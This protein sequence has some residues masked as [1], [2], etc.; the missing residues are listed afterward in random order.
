MQLRAK[1]NDPNVHSNYGAYLRDVAKDDARAEQAYLRALELDPNHSN[2][3]GNLANLLWER[4]ELDRAEEFYRHALEANPDNVNPRINFGKFLLW[5]RDDLDAARA[6][7]EQGMPTDNADLLALYCELLVRE[8]AYARAV[9]QYARLYELRPES[10]EVALNYGTVLQA[11]GTPPAAVEPLYRQVLA[12]EPGNGKAKLNLAQIRY[13]LGADEEALNL[14]RGAL[15]SPLEDGDRTEALWCWYA[16]VQ[17]RECLVELRTLLL[18]GAR[19]PGWDLTPVAARAIAVG[20]PSG[21]FLRFLGEV[22]VA[23]RPIGE[24]GRFSEWR[25]LAS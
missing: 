5:A 17:N 18:G 21:E 19:S 24:L 8:G 11:I 14:V 4:G 12:H 9:E 7:C 13:H 6:V 20:H 16:F 1:P 2:A 25:D 3:L 10:A 15:G 22:V 23:A